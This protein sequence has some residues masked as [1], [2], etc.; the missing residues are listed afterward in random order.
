[1]LH[2]TIQ[3]GGDPVA[4]LTVMSMI[5]LMDVGDDTFEAGL[6]CTDPAGQ[7]SHVAFR[8][9]W[10]FGKPEIDI[11]QVMIDGDASHG[12]A[13]TARH[14]DRLCAALIAF[15]PQVIAQVA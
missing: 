14:A 1:M 2:S 11:K 10:F 15:Y 3:T 7:I 6:R 8:F 4:D 5:H 9:Y 13:F 12:A